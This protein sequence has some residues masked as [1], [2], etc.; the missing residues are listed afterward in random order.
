MSLHSCLKNFDSCIALASEMNSASQVDKAT[1]CCFWLYHE[2]RTFVWQLKIIPVTLRLSL[3]DFP[4]SESQNLVNFNGNSDFLNLIA[5]NFW[6]GTKWQKFRKG[7]I[8]AVITLDQHVLAKLRHMSCHDIYSQE[9]ILGIDCA[10]MDLHIEMIIFVSY[11]T[12]F[13]LSCHLCCCLDRCYC[14]PH[15]EASEGDWLASMLARDEDCLAVVSS[16]LNWCR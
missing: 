1:V 2:I 11:F 14:S 16:L 7:Q 9:N 8:L 6:Q 13:F 15:F 5:T 4:Q 12:F 10:R 3:T